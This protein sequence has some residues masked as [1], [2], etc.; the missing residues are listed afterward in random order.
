MTGT[1]R[2]M[3]AL[4]YFS[5]VHKWPVLLYCVNHRMTHLQRMLPLW[6]WARHS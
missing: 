1:V 3:R 5:D 6:S 4:K 2:D